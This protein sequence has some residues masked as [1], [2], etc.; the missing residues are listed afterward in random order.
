M[1][2]INWEEYFM[3]LAILSSYRSKDPVMKVG[4]CIVEPETN[5]V[6]SLGYNGFPRGCSDNDFPWEKGNKDES[7]NKFSYVVHAEMNAILNSRNDLRGSRIYTTLSPCK[8]CM[9]AIAQTGIKEIIYLNKYEHDEKII[10]KILLH[11]GITMR[12]F[13]KKHKNISI[14]I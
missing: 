7:L 10:K 1:S 3:S 9:K 13:G 2:N 5:I 12:E 4:A 6:L 11:T 14:E 8:E